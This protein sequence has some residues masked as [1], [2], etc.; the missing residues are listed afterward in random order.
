MRALTSN[1]RAARAVN[2]E[3][4]HHVGAEFL[5]AKGRRLPAG[6]LSYTGGT[7]HMVAFYSSGINPESLSTYIA[8]AEAAYKLPNNLAVNAYYTNTGAPAPLNQSV[9]TQEFAKGGQ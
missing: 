8:N 5:Q 7:E 6:D 3:Q 1:R 2:T 9:T 4:A